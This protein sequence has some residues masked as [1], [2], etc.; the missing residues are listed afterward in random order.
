MPDDRANPEGRVP[1]KEGVSGATAPAGATIIE[2][3]GGAAGGATIIEGAAGG[4][5][6]I[7]G[8]QARAE[9]SLNL[10]PGGKFEEYTLQEPLRVT[11]GEA[12]LWFIADSQGTG[13][14]LK[15]YRYGIKP[16]KEITEKIRSLG[17][18]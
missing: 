1:P 14:V 9:A 15:L 2:G 3:A 17:H 13:Y 6:I 10:V 5:T 11:S 8:A 4:S 7:E 18:D 12:D 16:K